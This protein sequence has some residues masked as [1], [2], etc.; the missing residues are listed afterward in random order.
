VF[1]LCP[2]HFPS[3]DTV[4]HQSSIELHSREKSRRLIATVSAGGE[5]A[6]AAAGK[7]DLVSQ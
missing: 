3:A 5:L 1:L 7:Q 2:L 4:V 6:A